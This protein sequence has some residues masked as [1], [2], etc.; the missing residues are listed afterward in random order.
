MTAIET[1]RYY[2]KVRVITQHTEVDYLLPS[3]IQVGHF[4]MAKGL[5]IN[6]FPL[7]KK[8]KYRT[9]KKFPYETYFFTHM[10]T[11]KNIALLCVDRALA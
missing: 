11:Y 10:Y 3:W 8:L 6:V 7:Y 1:L 9:Q 2:L 5:K 4:V